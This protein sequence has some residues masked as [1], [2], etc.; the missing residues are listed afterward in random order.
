MR[1]SA[2]FFAAALV[3]L[4]ACSGPDTTDGARD[5]DA[6]ADGSRDD[7]FDI[8]VPSAVCDASAG[9]APGTATGS[10]DPLGATAGQVRAG[11]MTAAMLPPDRTGLATWAAGDLILANDKIAVTI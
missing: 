2:G 9:I 3:Q 1:A 4:A 7:T 11:P 6:T 5:A 10:A 8:D